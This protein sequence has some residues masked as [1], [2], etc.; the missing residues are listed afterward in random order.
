MDGTPRGEARKLRAG[1][2][3]LTQGPDALT[4]EAR[5]RVKA[6]AKLSVRRIRSVDTRLHSARWDVAGRVSCPD[7][8]FNKGA[9]TG[10]FAFIGFLFWVPH[11]NV[12][13]I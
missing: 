4:E 2:Q 6:Y 9:L 8:L 12:N 11:L 10:N 1:T 13:V 5:R 7:A 3:R